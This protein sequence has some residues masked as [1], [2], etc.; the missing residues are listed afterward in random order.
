MAHFYISLPSNSSMHYYPNN[1]VTR[2]TTRLENGISLSGD[3]EVGLVEIQY[4]HTWFNLEKGEGQILYLQSVD[5]VKRSGQF[6]NLLR[7]TP[8]YYDS[9]IDLLHAINDQIE[10][11]II[12][13]ELKVFS[14]FQYNAITKRISATVHRGTNMHFSP[15]L[16][17]MLGIDDVQNPVFNDRDELLH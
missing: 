15:A 14:R 9:P 5:S 6:N 1:T 2:Y 17:S 12:M 3:W 13:H 16:C 10:E 4:Q 11:T 8:G 7:L